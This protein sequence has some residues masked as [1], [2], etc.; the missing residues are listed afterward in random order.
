MLRVWQAGLLCD[1]LVS[2]GLDRREMVLRG[3]RAHEGAGVNMSNRTATLR[4]APSGAKAHKA[5]ITKPKAGKSGGG[6]SGGRGRFGLGGDGEPEAKAAAHA[7]LA[8][9]LAAGA[10]DGAL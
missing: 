3:L 10:D 9:L 8:R 1:G 4:P 2:A 6:G 7:V 5:K